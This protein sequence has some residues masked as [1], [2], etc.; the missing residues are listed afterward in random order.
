MAHMTLISILRDQICML[1]QG[2]IQ[3][4]LFTL[5]KGRDKVKVDIGLLLSF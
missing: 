4:L 5:E 1:N 2:P 3:P